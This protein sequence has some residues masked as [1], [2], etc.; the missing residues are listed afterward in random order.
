MNGLDIIRYTKSPFIDYIQSKLLKFF[1][2]ECEDNE[3]KFNFYD[4]PKEEVLAPKNKEKNIIWNY[5][6]LSVSKEEQVKRCLMTYIGLLQDCIEN[7]ELSLYSNSKYLY[8][9]MIL[10]LGL[11]IVL[12]VIWLILPLSLSIVTIIPLGYLI[13]VSIIYNIEIYKGSL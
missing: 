3:A 6:L 12:M 1:I 4:D 9:H 13:Y 11:C 10:I 5:L 2:D 8:K 7:S